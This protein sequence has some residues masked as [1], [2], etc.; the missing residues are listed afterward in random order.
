MT[1]RIT[2]TTPKE[3][4]PGPKDTGEPIIG[5]R[6]LA[7]DEELVF[8]QG[9][10]WIV[11]GAAAHCDF[12]IDDECVSEMHCLIERRG[13]S[14]LLVH[15]VH[16]K[17]RTWLNNGPLDHGELIMGAML[18]IGTTTLVPYTESGPDGPTLESFLRDAV[19]KHGSVRR[20]AKALGMPRSTLGDWLRRREP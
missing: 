19:R 18:T 11:V 4:L 1:E 7:T 16:S 9:K 5:L 12:T 13:L 14:R 20:A 17:N 10:Q 8:P 2:I 6:V 15:D 3:A